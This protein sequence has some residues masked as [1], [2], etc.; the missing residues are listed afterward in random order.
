MKINTTYLI[1]H[2]KFNNFDKSKWFLKRW[3][4]AKSQKVGEL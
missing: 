3:R 2:N 1:S 4:D